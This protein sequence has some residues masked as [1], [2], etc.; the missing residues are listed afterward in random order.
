MQLLHW[1]FFQVEGVV[2]LG[3]R[4]MSMVVEWRC[5]AGG[6]LVGHKGRG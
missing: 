1:S 4:E 5:V 2:L 3:G 6:S